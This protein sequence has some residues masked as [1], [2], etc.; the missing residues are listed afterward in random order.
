MFS[1]SHCLQSVLTLGLHDS[2]VLIS[3]EGTAPPCWKYRFRFSWNLTCFAWLMGVPLFGPFANGGPFSMAG[4]PFALFKPAG[5]LNMS[6]K[7]LSPHVDVGRE[8]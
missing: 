8:N 4:R 2:G 6:L 1:N 7:D 3:G 5:R